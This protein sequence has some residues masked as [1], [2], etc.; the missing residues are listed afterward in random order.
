MRPSIHYFTPLLKL[1][2]AAEVFVVFKLLTHK[3][4]SRNTLDHQ[5]FDYYNKLLNEIVTLFEM[6][7]HE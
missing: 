4:F 7:F 1:D 5:F 2:N 3:I 6:V